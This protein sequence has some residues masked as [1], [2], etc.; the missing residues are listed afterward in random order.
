MTNLNCSNKPDEF[1]LE[2]SNEVLVAFAIVGLAAFA[3]SKSFASWLEDIERKYCRGQLLVA[4]RRRHSW[5]KSDLSRLKALGVNDAAKARM[6]RLTGRGRP[7]VTGH[8]PLHEMIQSKL[9]GFCLL[10]GPDALR[11]DRRRTF[12]QWPW[13][14][15]HVEAYYRGEHE[16]A[17]R[18]GLKSPSLEAETRVGAA[19]GMSTSMVR[20]V[21]GEIRRM[22]Q[23]DELSANFPAQTLEEYERWMKYGLT[24]S[25]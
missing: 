12:K 11:Q 22:R 19:L 1:S 17:K 9:N 16:L 15:H 14:K 13:W 18:Q 6:Q 24:I 8:Q 25:S 23:E 5:K 21:C 20:R 2:L 7:V 3:V 10:V 4:Y